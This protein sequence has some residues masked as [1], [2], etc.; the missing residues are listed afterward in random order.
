MCTAPVEP[1]QPAILAIQP[2]SMAGRNASISRIAT[3]APMAR[4][5]TSGQPTRSSPVMALA[6]KAGITRPRN[7]DHQ[8]TD[9]IE[10]DGDRPSMPGMTVNQPSRSAWKLDVRDG[11]AQQD[12]NHEGIAPIARS[13]QQ[14]GKTDREH[15]QE[16]QIHEGCEA[17]H[18]WLLPPPT[19]AVGNAPRDPQAEQ[20]GQSSS[21]GCRQ[22]RP[23]ARCSEQ[24]SGDD[25]RCESEQH[26][27]PVPVEIES[28]VM[29]AAVGEGDPTDAAECH[30]HPQR[31]GETGEDRC[32][33]I[34][35][36][37]IRCSGTAFG[38]RRGHSADHRDRKP[39]NYY[40]ESPKSFSSLHKTP[41]MV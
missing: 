40:T 8:H 21:G 5:S 31:Y 38:M 11:E 3:G 24:K 19:R 6:E 22:T 34:R 33:Q 14:Y 18:L 1:Q 39:R 41:A 27:V 29:A 32:T 7:H 23:V 12:Q 2:S 26:F 10:G 20:C 36:V 37:G 28:A 15:R 25:R 13:P 30:H 17:A 35:R 16:T 9:Q 4:P